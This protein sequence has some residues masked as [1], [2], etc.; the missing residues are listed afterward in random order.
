[1]SKKCIFYLLSFL[2]VMSNGL[3]RFTSKSQNQMVIQRLDEKYANDDVVRYRKPG[4]TLKLKKFDWSTCSGPDALAQINE[5]DLSEPLSIPGNVTVT[6]DSILRGDITTP[7]K[8]IVQVQKKVGFLWIE[9]PCVDNVGSCN[10]EDL[11][12][13]LPFPPGVP[14]PEPFLALGLPC[15]CPVLQGDYFIR[16]KLVYIPDEHIPQFLARGQYSVQVR[17]SINSQEVICFQSKFVLV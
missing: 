2:V 4:F 6:V 1:M 11:C 7:L 10:Y 14:C 15:N 16:N 5:F 12:A 3:G 17:A 8:V 13:E 9:V